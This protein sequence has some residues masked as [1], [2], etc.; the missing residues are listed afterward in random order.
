MNEKY[1]NIQ[2]N[3]YLSGKFM[4]TAIKHIFSAM[5]TGG[6]HIDYKMGIELSKDG[7]EEVVPYRESKF[8][9]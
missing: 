8:V 5:S 3:K 2:L 7:L 6:T 9:Y 1:R 4:I